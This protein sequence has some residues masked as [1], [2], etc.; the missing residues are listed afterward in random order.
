MEQ[1]R[2]SHAQ[3]GARAIPPGSAVTRSPAVW[4]LAVVLGLLAGCRRDATP[5]DIPYVAGLEISAAESALVTGRS[6][7][8]AVAAF[9]SAGGPVTPRQLEWR[10]SNGALLLVDAQGLARAVAGSRGGDAFVYAWAPPSVVQD[11]LLVHVAVPGEVK[12]VY[13]PPPGARFDPIGGPA[14]GQDGRVY[15]LEDYDPAAQASNLV[16]LSSTGNVL[17]KADLPGVAYNYAMLTAAGSIAAVGER[18]YVVR[19]T[20]T[21]LWEATTAAQI[22]DFIAAAVTNDRLIAAVVYQVVSYPL[23]QPQPV[24]I[25]PTASKGGWIV[26][27]TVDSASGLVYMKQSD[28]SLFVFRL[29]DGTLVRRMPDL[30][31]LADRRVFGHGPVVARGRVYLPLASRLAA[32]DTTGALLWLTSTAFGSTEPVLDAAGNLYFQNG[33]RGLRALRPDGSERWSLPIVAQ[34]WS[35]LGGPAL[36]HGGIIYA[37]STT[38]L[39]AVDTTG[40]ILWRFSA[41]SAGTS[42][43]FLGSPAI[44]PDGTIYTF[45]R[46]HVYALWGPAGPEPASPWPMWRHDAQRTG[47]AR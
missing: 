1:Q 7:Q 33:Y 23:D 27:P 14:L 17:W 36:A 9:D 41:D 5:P 10:S 11:S 19:S 32:F 21:I 12:W 22:P 6:L 4:R 40:A 47:W 44:A 26:P 20:G 16:A 18:V 29:N 42:Q 28:D 15:V 46:S 13:A 24:W 45:T 8:L 34:R 30:D 3:L 31:S 2:P 37:A 38:G 35:W 43:A 25:T 39:Y